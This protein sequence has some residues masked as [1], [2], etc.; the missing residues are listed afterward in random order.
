MSGWAEA[1]VN[2]AV[3]A[4]VS[5]GRAELASDLKR[6]ME[7]ADLREL[8]ALRNPE[9]DTLVD[10][11]FGVMSV[12][13]LSDMVCRVAEVFSFDHC[14]FHSVQERSAEFYPT[15]IITTYPVSWVEE[16]TLRHYE[17]IDPVMQHAVES[18]GGFFWDDIDVSSPVVRSFFTRAAAHGVGPQGYTLPV[19][20]ENGDRFALSVSSTLSAP[21][22]QD[23]LNAVLSDLN[24]VTRILAATFVRVAARGRPTDTALTDDQHLVLRAIASGAT[25]ADLTALEFQYGSFA[26]VEKSLCELFH[27][28]T[29]SQAAVVAAR[30]GLL[31]AAPLRLSEVFRVAKADQPAEPPRK[32]AEIAYLRRWAKANTRE[33]TAVS[34]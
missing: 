16:Y 8:D 29:L 34:A 4:L 15:K 14:T 10:E 2:E 7:V 11:L 22:F 27:A 12:N 13:E 32:T 31:D 5:S 18:A 30:I 19:E 28:K 26:T 20:S 24:E 6:L 21:E 23:A 25:A 3:D 17:N 1:A 9:A 33:D